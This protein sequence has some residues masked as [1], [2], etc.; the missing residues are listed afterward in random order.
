[1]AAVNLLLAHGTPEQVDEWVPPMLDGRASGT[2]CL[3]EPQAGSS[4]ADITT[5]A[6]PADDGS[7]RVTGTKMWISGGEH[8]LTPNIVH[9]VLARI[10]GGP[11]GVKGISLVAV[12]RYLADGA[13]NDVTLV[14]LNHK[15]GYRGTA[16]TLL[17]FE[18]AVGW[19]VGD[20]HAGLAAMFHM[21]NEA[22]VGVGM[23]AAALG[24]TGYLHSW[25]T[26]GPARRAARSPDETSPRRWCRSSSTPTS[27][28][29]CSR[30]S[31]TPR[32][33]WRSASTARA[34]W[35]RRTPAT[36]P[37]APPSCSTC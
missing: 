32:A 5:R 28:G 37:G 13:R 14:G 33:P 22:R 15:M 26:P 16:N 34:W 36:T 9:L 30:R 4:L 18:G 35:T 19:R 23:G 1:M 20:E 17:A 12:P 7:Y 31:P 3:S 24:V 27:A 21:M 8:E 11:P 6:E 25:T 10:P 29:C 2:M